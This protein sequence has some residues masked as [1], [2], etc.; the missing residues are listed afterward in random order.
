MSEKRMD[1]W[2]FLWSAAVL[3]RQD[4]PVAARLVYQGMLNRCNGDRRC[5]PSYETLA[6]DCATTRRVVIRTVGTLRDLGLI[7]LERATAST[8]GFET[9]R[10][11]RLPN[12]FILRDPNGV[13]ARTPRKRANEVTPRT[14][15]KRPRGDQAGTN[16]VTYRTP[17][18]QKEL[19]NKSKS[20]GL[21]AA[22]PPPAAQ[23]QPS[24]PPK[25]KPRKRDKLFDAVCELFDLETKTKGGQRRVGALVRDFRLLEATPDELVRR[26]ERYRARWPD[27][28]DTPDAL[29]KHWNRFAADKTAAKSAGARVQSMT[30][31]GDASH[32]STTTAHPRL[33]A[34]A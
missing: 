7:V 30:N 10:P 2:R 33:S 24:K 29:L 1:R 26:R 16:G 22:S 23:K 8:P 5:F 12:V 31:Y 15:R 18:Q 25:R 6:D 11:D 20:Y 3:K 19:L 14:P 13:T 21:T 17:K 4:I 28:E 27:V 32:A 9:W 34:T